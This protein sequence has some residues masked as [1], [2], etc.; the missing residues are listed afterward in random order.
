M[1][2][3][4][5]G[6]KVKICLKAARE[7]AELTQAEAAEKLGVHAN[8]L[9]RYEDLDNPAVPTAKVIERMEELYGI[10]YSMLR[11]IRD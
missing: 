2:E 9:S 5:E 4:L 7:N 10:P 11:F 1:K 3:T 8:T 6:K